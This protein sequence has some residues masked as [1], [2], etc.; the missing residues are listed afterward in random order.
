MHIPSTHEF[1]AQNIFLIPKVFLCF[2]NVLTI[3]CSKMSNITFRCWLNLGNML[4]LRFAM[5]HSCT[6][7]SHRLNNFLWKLSDCWFVITCCILSY[8]NTQLPTRSLKPSPRNV[9]SSG[10]Q[11]NKFRYTFAAR[12]RYQQCF[13]CNGNTNNNLE[14]RNSH[15]WLII[16]LNV[17]FSNKT[18]VVSILWPSQYRCQYN[19]LLTVQTRSKFIII[20]WIVCML[21]GVDL[22]EGPDRPWPPLSRIW[23]PA[24]PFWNFWI[25]PWLLPF[26]WGIRVFAVLQGL[27]NKY[28][29]WN[30]KT[31]F[32]TRASWLFVPLVQIMLIY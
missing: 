26:Q 8:K 15:S 22:G 2:Q 29:T 30:V 14:M 17:A 24:P 12:T 31:P 7:H 32:S 5:T 19:V 1:G 25:R 18:C 28:A 6:I 21:S 13:S 16:F 23:L 27:A 4:W 10:Q 9:S 3:E 11:S 20:T